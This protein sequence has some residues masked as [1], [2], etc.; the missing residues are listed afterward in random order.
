MVQMLITLCFFSLYAFI[1]LSTSLSSVWTA[2]L[3][4][5]VRQ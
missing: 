1:G 2:R 5:S 4:K 3:K